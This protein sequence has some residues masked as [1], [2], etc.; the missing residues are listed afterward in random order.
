MKIVIYRTKYSSKAC[1]RQPLENLKGYGLLD[2]EHT[3]SNFLKVVFNKFY[4]LDSWILCSIWLWV[5]LSSV[6]RRDVYSDPCQTSVMELFAKVINGS[7]L[8]IRFHHRCLTGF[9]PT[10][11][12]LIKVNNRNT[13]KMCEICSKATIKTT[14][15]V[16]VLLLLTL[17][18]FPRFF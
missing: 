12:Y 15:V 18:I 1:G 14:N 4:L 16:L 7:K 3:L 11:I 9:Y 13:R 2:A 8:A 10:N 17:N 6:R 5:I